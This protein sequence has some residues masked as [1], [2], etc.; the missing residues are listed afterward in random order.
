[1]NNHNMF[2]LFTFSKTKKERKKTRCYPVIFGALVRTGWSPAFV[3]Y[4]VASPPGVEKV[5][6]SIFGSNRVMAK[7]VR[8]YTYFC[9]IRCVT[10]IVCVGGMSWLQTGVTQLHAQL[11]LP[12]KGRAIVA[13]G[14]YQPSSEVWFV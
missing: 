6:G 1:M 9:Y 7:D 4:Q 14:C 11:G 12:D 10:L 13:L 2:L 8:S 5:I 3:A